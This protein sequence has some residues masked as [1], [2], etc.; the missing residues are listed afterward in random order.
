MRIATLIVLFIVINLNAQAQKTNLRV[1]LDMGVKHYDLIEELVNTNK[2]EGTTFSLLNP[3]LY[4]ITDKKLSFLRL[5]Y[6]SPSLESEVTNSDFS[7][8]LIDVSFSYNYLRIVKNWDKFS[9]YLGGNL[10]THLKVY[11]QD[12][13]A[14]STRNLN[15]IDAF[16][17]SL[18]N[19]RLSSAIKMNLNSWNVYFQTEIGLLNYWTKAVPLGTNYEF[20]MDLFNGF[21]EFK[22]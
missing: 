10:N 16:E 22:V 8:D 4:W 7:G 2:Y 14:Q 11:F 20:Q 17:G 5:S 6:S 1:G 9:I 13:Q 18:I 21:N 15:E 19:L 12:F 3:T